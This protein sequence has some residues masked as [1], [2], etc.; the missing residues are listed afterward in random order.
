MSVTGPACSSQALIK[1]V[2]KWSGHTWTTT[3]L[4]PK[5]ADDLFAQVARAGSV[6][7]IWFT[8]ND[9]PTLTTAGLLGD[10]L[11]TAGWTPQLPQA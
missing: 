9:P 7:R 2:A 8:G 11:Q 10:D 4:V 3:S 6:V 5:S 1:Q